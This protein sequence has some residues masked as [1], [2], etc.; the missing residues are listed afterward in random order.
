MAIK[1]VKPTSHGRRAQTYSTYEEVTKKEP[2]KSLIKIISKSGGRNSNGRITCRH[3]GGGNKRF[4]RIID[5]NCILH[6]SKILASH[7]SARTLMTRILIGL[8]RT[9]LCG[10]AVSVWFFFAANH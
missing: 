8:R 3:R 4:L 1:K 7:Q 9:I 10:K 6:V 2:E 5:F